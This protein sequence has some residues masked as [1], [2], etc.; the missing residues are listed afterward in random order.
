[1]MINR[2]INSA[3]A[4]ELKLVKNISKIEKANEREREGGN[5]T[6]LISSYIGLSYIRN[7]FFFR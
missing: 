3:S 4:K 1:M 7:S 5:I 2:K 6:R